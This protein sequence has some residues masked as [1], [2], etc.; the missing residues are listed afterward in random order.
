MQ[1]GDGDVLLLRRQHEAA[2]EMEKVQLLKLRTLS[3]SFTEADGDGDGTISREEWVAHVESIFGGD[4]SS[5]WT[6]V[7]AAVFAQADTDGDGRVSLGEFQEAATSLSPVLM[8]CELQ[9]KC[10]LFSI[11]SIENAKIMENC[12]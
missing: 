6:G 4:E 9:Y 5:A 12:P 7:A 11:C 8:Y 10:Q 3:E 1:F 2:V